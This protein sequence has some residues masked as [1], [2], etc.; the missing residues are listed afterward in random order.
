MYIN[1][2]T[3]EKIKKTLAAF[4]TVPVFMTN[5]TGLTIQNKTK[6]YIKLDKRDVLNT[7]NE[8]VLNDSNTINGYEI[9]DTVNIDGQVMHIVCDEEDLN[10]IE[11]IDNVQTNEES[12]NITE[13]IANEDGTEY[14]LNI[15]GDLPLDFTSVDQMITFYS[16]VFQVRED[17]ASDIINSQIDQNYEAFYEN[18]T[19]NGVEYNSR[20]EAILR[21]I[22]DIFSYP[23]NYNLTRE[24]IHTEEYDLTEYSPEEL[25]YKFAHVLGVNPYVAL[26]V[27]YSE[28]GRGLNSY[29]FLT[30]YNVAGLHPR[31]GYTRPT[32]RNGYIIYQNPADG[33]CDYCII[34]HD[35]FYVEATDGIDR[36]NT[37]SRSYSECPSHWRNLVTS[38]YYN[39]INNGY[40]SNYLSRNPEEDFIYSEY[41]AENRLVLGL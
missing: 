24:E 35:Y 40:E 9:I 41:E 21:T 23:E 4:T 22:R 39:L 16:T 20:E 2:E 37:M 29:N 27:A 6:D 38:N 10:N 36:I 33:L 17:I 8:L 25:L 26:S 13:E 11:N 1:K 14:P 18:N 7:K 19:L 28:A 34:L 15:V 31:R 5:L 30:N 12:E 32:N 3:K